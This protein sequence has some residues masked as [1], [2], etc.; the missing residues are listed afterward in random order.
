MTI[1]TEIQQLRP[2]ITAALAVLVTLSMTTPKV[3]MIDRF[4]LYEP[5]QAFHGKRPCLNDDP[6]AIRF[7][8]SLTE[9]EELELIMRESRQEA[10]L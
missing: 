1:Q 7:Y 6:D 9:E 8:A 10:K 4:S 5:I 3:P 2:D